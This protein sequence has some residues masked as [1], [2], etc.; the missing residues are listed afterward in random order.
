M[1]AG[2]STVSM[3]LPVGAKSLK[4]EVCSTRPEAWS[5]TA[6]CVT[7]DATRML[8]MRVGRSGRTSAGSFSVGE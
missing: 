3:E 5:S 1:Y 6:A 4:D 7:V 8:R 2:R